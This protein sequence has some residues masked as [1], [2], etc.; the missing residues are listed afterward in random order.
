MKNAYSNIKGY[1]SDKENTSTVTNVSVDNR[2]LAN[3]VI[4]AK[5]KGS[6]GRSLGHVKDILI[7]PD[8][9]AK[10]IIIN[11]GGVL[12]LGGKLVALDYDVLKGITGSKT[13]IVTVDKDTLKT[14]TAYNEK[15]GGVDRSGQPIQTMPEGYYSVVD[16]S[17]ADVVD[18][19]GQKV[20]DINTVAMKDSVADYLIVT[21]DKK[22]GLGGHHAALAL[23]ALDINNVEGKYL[24]RL[25]AEQSAQFKNFAQMTK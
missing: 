2:L 14:A 12:G 16:L 9:T 13:V 22:L 4:N 11:D 5:V 10:K 23:P 17:N 24:V 1:F 15:A 25:S 20:A 8:G 3:Q 6:D 18:N 7:T 21:F 19:Q